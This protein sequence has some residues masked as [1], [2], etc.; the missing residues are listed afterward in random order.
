MIS[1]SSKLT[2]HQMGFACLLQE[3]FWLAK[4]CFCVFV[5]FEYSINFGQ[6]VEW[7]EVGVELFFLDA[8][9]IS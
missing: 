6:K 9:I 4:N 3:K 7:V 2:F 5:F 8:I 1:S